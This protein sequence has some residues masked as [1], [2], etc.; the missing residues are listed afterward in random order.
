MRLSISIIPAAVLAVSALAPA[1]MASAPAPTPF[2]VHVSTGTTLVTGHQV[3][4]GERL[5]IAGRP[6]TR[7]ASASGTGTTI[8]TSSSPQST[9]MTSSAT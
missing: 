1:A 2:G 9:R 7:G 8:P 4:S 5:V 3:T 6:V